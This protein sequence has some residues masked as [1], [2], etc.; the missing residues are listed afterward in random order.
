MFHIGNLEISCHITHYVTHH[1]IC[2]M[3][4]HLS[5]L[6]HTEHVISCSEWDNFEDHIT[7]HVTCHVMHH[8]LHHVMSHI[9]ENKN[10]ICPIMHYMTHHVMPYTSHNGPRHMSRHTSCHMKCHVTQDITHQVTGDRSQVGHWS[11]VTGRSLVMGHRWRG[12]HFWP[13]TIVPWGN[14]GLIK[15]W[16]DSITAWQTIINS[17]FWA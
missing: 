7:C 3:T 11:R 9:T 1:V 16:H 10:I 13:I 4:C 5:D 17:N 2:H 15:A 14:R 8:I 12:H 6:L